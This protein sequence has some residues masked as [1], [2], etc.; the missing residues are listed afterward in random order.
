MKKFAFISSLLLTIAAIPLAA[1][2]TDSA[3]TIRGGKFAGQSVAIDRSLAAKK[4][5]RFW[6]VSSIRGDSRIVGWNPSSLPAKVAFHNTRI[7]GED[8]VA[9]WSILR[10]MEGDMGMHLFEPTSLANEDDDVNIIVVDLKPM[11]GNEG[12]T[13]ITWST[14]GAPY[15]A[16]VYLGSRSLLHDS[17][18][19]T[20]ELMH[21]LGFGHTGAWDSIMNPGP[22]G[23]GSLTAQDV[24]YAQ[25]AFESRTANERDDMWARL[26]LAVS[27][28]GKPV[29]DPDMY[30]VCP[31]VITAVGEGLS[32]P[33]ELPTG[34]PLRS[35]SCYR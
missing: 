22:L 7:D 31:R 19:V 13:Y 24:A 18:V 35:S 33:M 17:R 6:R 5:S 25:A 12:V 9:F 20:H 14:N 30:P 10:K 26:A 27:R 29:R 2:R 3:W 11:I 15:D 8:S 32:G 21:A 4:S 34:D 1:Q 16:R 23:P 28:E